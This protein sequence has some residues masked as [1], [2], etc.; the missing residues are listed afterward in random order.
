MTAS[1][2][3]DVDGD[4]DVTC[5]GIIIIIMALLLLLLLWLLWLLGGEAI[6]SGEAI[7]CSLRKN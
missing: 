5:A 1:S 3:E 6:K 7:K 2:D 4:R